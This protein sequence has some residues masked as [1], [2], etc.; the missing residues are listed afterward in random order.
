MVANIL[1][2][3]IEAPPHVFYATSN[4]NKTDKMGK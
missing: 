1:L 4:L 3:E 2:I